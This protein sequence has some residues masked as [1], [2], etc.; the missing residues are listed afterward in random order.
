MYSIT[1]LFNNPFYNGLTVGVL[2]AMAFTVTKKLICKNSSSHGCKSSVKSFSQISSVKASGEFKMALLV[3]H[4][5][6]MGKGKVAAQVRC[7]L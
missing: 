2:T 5:L 3:R 6:K 7:I 1:D 4:D